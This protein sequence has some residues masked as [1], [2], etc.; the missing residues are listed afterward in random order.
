MRHFPLFL[1]L[2]DRPVLLVG[3]G[4]AAAAKARLLI[5]AG[6]QLRVAAETPGEEIA[7][8]AAD[9]RLSLARRS[10]VAADL[11]GVALAI[12]ASG[13]ETLD[14]KVAGA[15]RAANLPVNVV[16][17]PDLSTF[18]MPA[19]VDR[20]PLTIAISS[21]G[22]APLLAARLRAWLE[23]RLP[24]RLGALAR[25]ANEFRGAVKA[26]I[27][28]A[29]GRRRFWERFFDG[30]LAER[31]LAGDEPEARSAMLSLVN[32][33]RD[34]GPTGLVQIV[35]A[36]PGDPELLTLKALR[37]I[38]DADAIVYDRLVAPEILG[39]ARREAERFYV[40]KTPGQHPH[41][42][43]DIDALLA[44]L[45]AAGKRVVRLKGG[46]P[47]VF[48]RGG[49]ELS[50]L[51]A[52]GIPVQVVPGIT[53]ATGCGAAS[54][55]PL[56]HR[57]HASA[58]TFVTGQ[59]RN[60]EPDV[61][62]AALAQLHQTI[63]V[64]MGVAA[65]ERIAGRLIAGGLAGSIPA[66]VIENGTRPEERALFGTLATLPALVRDEEVS[67]PALLVIGEV[68]ALAPGAVVETARTALEAQAGATSA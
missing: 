2:E 38:E 18:I 44:R 26:R 40:G 50:Y 35:G 66:A 6:A 63:V 19:I 46:D 59:G 67:G 45:A 24:A 11:S 1:D 12:S 4:T 30:N 23:A 16:D 57:A 8:L 29:A 36:G 3:G 17:S 51:Q 43:A 27:R 68:V 10:F 56:T 7:A 33:H 42:Q 47:F 61:D 20:D 52:R 31:V 15:A 62:W 22:A 5:A 48:G 53:A 41:S 55:I 37:L 49:E 58:V 25:F 34:E 32:R 21:G 54:G 14:R 13:E 9:G 65:V 28:E 60:G 39:Y 64:Y